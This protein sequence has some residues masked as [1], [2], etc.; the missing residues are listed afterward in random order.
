MVVPDGG[1]DSADHPHL[2][3]HPALAA[4]LPTRVN[5]ERAREERRGEGGGRG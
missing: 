3:P 1:A 4:T 2:K 5:G